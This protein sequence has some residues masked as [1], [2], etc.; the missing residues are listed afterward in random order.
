MKK[1]LL[2]LATI[3]VIFTACEKDDTTDGNG[4]GSTTEVTL[5]QR[6][7]T[8]KKYVDC[9]EAEY[10]VIV[11]SEYSWQ[12]TTM[13]D[14]IRISTGSKELTF[15]VTNNYDSNKREGTIYIFNANYNAAAELHV[16]Q[17]AFSPKITVDD[18]L[19]ISFKGG[20]YY[21]GVTANCGYSCYSNAN[22]FSVVRSETYGINGIKITA[23]ANVDDEPRSAEIEIRSNDGSGI[24]KTIKVTQSKFSEGG[25]N[26]IYYTSTDNRIVTP[27]DSN[28]FSYMKI[29]ISKL[30][31]N[32]YK[33]GQG[34]IV[35]DYNLWGIG[36]NAFRDC[37]TLKSITIPDRVELISKNVFNDCTS[38]KEVYC[39]PTTPP[40]LQSYIFWGNIS[41]RKIYV[42]RNSVEAYKSAENWSIYADYIVGYDF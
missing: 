2:L 31:A 30:T 17:D 12:A 15:S 7:R 25:G 16:I 8:Y 3:G 36:N 37:T 11:N 23:E 14:W 20:S 18:E 24:S 5:S 13:N 22:W 21:M 1:L 33:N 4:A 10:K 41:G 6:A 38:L 19:N 26:I 42:P 28:A 27:Y 40:T 35:F 34:I 39:K 29:G 32:I 9:V